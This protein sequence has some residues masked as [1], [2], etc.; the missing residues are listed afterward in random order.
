[1]RGRRGD[2]CVL[3]IGEAGVECLADEDREGGSG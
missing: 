1:M 3:G 2:A